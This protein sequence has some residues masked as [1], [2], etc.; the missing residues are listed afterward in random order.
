MK[1]RMQAVSTFMLIALVLSLI[2]AAALPTRAAAAQAC[3]DWA[4]FVADV[5][6]LDGTR[7]DP[8]ATFTKTWRLRNI[9]TCTWTTAYTMFFEPSAS[10]T[11]MGNTTSVNLPSTVAPGAT[12]DVSVN[13]TAPGSAGHYFSYWKFKNAGGTPFGIG[14]NANRPWWVEI[15]VNGTPTGSVAY[16]FTANASSA[17]WSSGAGGLT[18]PG[19]DGDAKGFA[20]KIDQPNF[21]SGVPFT[22]PGLLVSPQ[23]LTNGFIQGS[24]PAFTVQ[25]GDRFQATAGCQAGATS[26]YVAYRL[27]YEVNGAV[28][29]FWQFRERFEGLTYNANLNL[30]PLAGQNVKFILYVSAWGSPVGDRAIWGNPVIARSG[31]RRSWATE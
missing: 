24:Y 1:A 5:T 30:S 10:S 31:E 20:L 25:S 28:R 2:P 29:T 11:Q 21:E 22:Q 8:G 13:M 7:Y 17:T 18:F 16:D 6:V 4:G 26:C 23:Q 27:D 3:S 12:V 15:F 14:F 19:A 9:G